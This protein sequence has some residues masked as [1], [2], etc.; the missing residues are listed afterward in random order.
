MRRRLVGSPG[1]FPTPLDE[2]W[3][4][5]KVRGT[6]VVVGGQGDAIGPDLLQ[7]QGCLDRGRYLR[8]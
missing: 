4:L 8:E 3:R 5:S 1:W 6:G 2:S 7:V